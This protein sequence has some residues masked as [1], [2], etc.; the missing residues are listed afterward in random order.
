M[1]DKRLTTFL[2]SWRVLEKEQSVGE[3]WPHRW[4][5]LESCMTSSRRSA[6][7]NGM[8]TCGHIGIAARLGRVHSPSGNGGSF[9]CDSHIIQKPLAPWFLCCCWVTK[10]WPTLCDLRD[11]ST[12]GFSVLHHLLRMLKLMSIGSVMPSNHIILCRPLL[13]LPSVFPSTQHIFK[14]HAWCCMHQ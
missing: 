9:S 13:L 8:C 1:E 5:V 10:S 11:C 4:P 3:S 2:L 14:L 7:S 12:P 6:E